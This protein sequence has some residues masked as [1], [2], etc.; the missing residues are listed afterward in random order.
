MV[1]STVLLSLCLVSWAYDF[2]AVAPT[3]QTLYYNIVD[4]GVEVTCPGSANASGWSAHTKPTGALVLPSIVVNGGNTYALVGVGRY[5]FYGC[6]GLSS[7]VVPEGVVTLNQAAFSGC[8]AMDTVSLPS[9]LVSLGLTAFYGCTSLSGISCAAAVPPTVASSTFGGITA[10]ACSLW[11]PCTSTAAYA[12]AT[13]W[14][15]FSIVASG[16]CNAT[17]T[18]MPNQAGRG[19]VTGSGSYA[20]GTVVSIAATPADGFFFAF[21]HDGDTVNPRLLTLTADTVVTAMFYPSQRDTVTVS[22]YVH[23]TV[24]LHDTIYTPVVYVDT[25]VVVDTLIVHDTVRVVDTIVP[26]YFRLQVNGDDGGIGIGSALVPAG[27]ELEIGAL[28]MEGYRF[29]EWD[30]GVVDNPRRVTLTGNVTRTARF[31]PLTGVDVVA[32]GTWTAVAEGRCIVVIGASGCD[33]ALYDMQGRRL[34]DG[35]ATVD[36]LVFRVP[37]QGVYLVSVDGSAARKVVV[38]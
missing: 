9:T 18:A 35:R 12:S 33:V 19:T 22:V 14:G 36:R 23:D 21:W 26:T 28:P 11:V 31:A 4:G 15:D 27:T 16:S 8:A 6:Y 29:A 7:V 38:E 1:I 37:A 2:S 30:D 25:V 5:A 32:A 34:V 17:L 3:G 13:G 24:T 10:S 20:V